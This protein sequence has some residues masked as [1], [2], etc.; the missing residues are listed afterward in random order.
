ML[1]MRGDGIENKGGVFLMW[2]RVEKREKLRVGGNFFGWGR[3]KKSN[4]MI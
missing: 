3:K 1:N 4:F 2:E